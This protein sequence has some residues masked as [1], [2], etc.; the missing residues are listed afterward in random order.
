[1]S[2]K[3]VANTVSDIVSVAERLKGND[4]VDPEDPTVIAEQELLSAANAIEAAARKISSLKPRQNTNA[5]SDFNK[6]Y[7]ALNLHNW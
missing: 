7:T 1:M 6:Y 4:L 5:V 2:S 3:K